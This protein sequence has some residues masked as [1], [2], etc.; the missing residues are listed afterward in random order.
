MMD[1]FRFIFRSLFKFYNRYNIQ[2]FNRKSLKRNTFQINTQIF[3]PGRKTRSRSEERFPAFFRHFQIVLPKC[4]QI[5]D[6]R[7]LALNASLLFKQLS[8]NV[9]QINQSSGWIS[10]RLRGWVGFWLGFGILLL[11]RAL[12]KK[13]F[14]LYLSSSLSLNCNYR[15]AN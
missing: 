1:A 6:S 7:G 14:R 9:K 3:L 10:R 12:M 15:S 11:G 13:V 4:R 5:A 2:Y 8:N